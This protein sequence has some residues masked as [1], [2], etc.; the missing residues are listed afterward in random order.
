MRTMAEY[1]TITD[2]ISPAQIRRWYAH[3]PSEEKLQ[4]EAALAHITGEHYPRTGV[5]DT[6]PNT[7]ERNRGWI[8]SN[9]AGTDGSICPLPTRCGTSL[10]D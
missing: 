4:L 1:L 7:D 5:L 10:A 9:N 6:K 8:G 2:G 3:L